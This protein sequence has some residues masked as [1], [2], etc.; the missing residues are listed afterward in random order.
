M[1]AQSRGLS[2][3]VVHTLLSTWVL[4]LKLGQIVDIL[5]DN[6][7]QVVGL[8]VSGDFVDRESLR[9]DGLQKR[10]RMGKQR[11]GEVLNGNLG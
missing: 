10:K 1:S 2:K 7:V 8:L 5:L 6:N 4:I 3:A 9:H 11:K